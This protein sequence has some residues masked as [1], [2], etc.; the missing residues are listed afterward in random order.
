M[1]LSKKL[2]E[3]CRVI[4]NIKLGSDIYKISLQA[5]SICAL[6]TAGQFVQVQTSKTLQPI[7]R[8]PISIADVIGDKLVLIYRIVGEGT[9]LLVNAKAGDII[10]I[11]GP[12]GS[13]FSLDAK[14]PLLVGGG[15]GIAPL[16][17]LARDY[18]LKT[19]VAV[20]LAGRCKEEIIFWQDMFKEFCDEIFVTTDDGTMGTCGN[21]LALLPDVMDNF[22]GVFACGPNIMLKAVAKC[23]KDKDIY[24]QI[25]LE[26][27]MACG[28]GACLA[29]SCS[30]TDGKRV[31]ICQNGPVFV[32]TEVEGYV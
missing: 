8:R 18:S 7:L 14:K 1:I 9:R 15:I 23:A 17:K 11:L 21:C 32:S 31:K 12:L 22:D 20:L 10:S 29:C 3:D 2:V 25:S 16:L 5:P 19:K 6:A 24:C 28:I 4:E 26:S 13:G 30:S 27:H